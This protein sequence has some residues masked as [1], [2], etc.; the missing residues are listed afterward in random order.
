MEQDVVVDCDDEEEEVVMFE[1][2]VD[3]TT[4]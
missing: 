4:M 2:V 3:M 1:D